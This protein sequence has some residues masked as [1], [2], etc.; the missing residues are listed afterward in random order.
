MSKVLILTRVFLRNGTD[1]MLKSKNKRG[2][3][4]NLTLLIIMAVLMISV[5]IPFGAF[6]AKGYDL[7]DPI[8]QTGILLGFG[9][10]LVSIAIFIFGIV[11]VLTTFYFSKDIENLLSLPVK[12]YQ[13]L[14]AKFITVLV[15]E[16]FTETIFL[17]PV[18]IA[19]GIKS[20]AGVVYYLYSAIV[21]LT[22][23]I[24]PLVIASA[25]NMFIM[26]FTNL[27]KHKDALKIAGGL[28]AMTFAIGINVVMQR[29]GSNI[30]ENPEHMLS[31]ITEGNNSL[32]RVSTRAFPSTRL[33]ALSLIESTTAKGLQNLILFLLVTAAFIGLFMVLAEM[34]Y[35]R[36]VVG[37]SESYSKRKVIV[38]EELDKRLTQKSSLKSYITKELRI[39]LRTPAYFINCV[40]MNFLLPAFLLLPVI[41][42]PK[43]LE[44]IRNASQLAD[45]PAILG[46]GVA[47]GFAL[48]VFL[49]AT[50]GITS[51]SISRE[52]QNLYV[53]KYLPLRYRDQ[54]MAK[55]LSG[56]I[57]NFI[58]VAIAVS[59][60]FAL[61]NPPVYALTLIAVAALQ[62]SLLMAFSG[63]FIDLHFPKLDWDNEQKAVKQN[64]N[65]MINMFLGVLVGAAVI[66]ITVRFALNLNHAFGL[67]MAAGTIFNIVLYRTLSTYGERLYMSIEP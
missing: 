29:A 61:I 22:L 6:I 15:Y 14:S 67:I 50:T 39:L 57:L 38:G 7:L 51:T 24:I 17:L 5:G 27:G 65:L 4:K 58:G 16:Y 34:L 66:F 52:G 23:P 8:G 36:G 32:I 56:V 1:T 53:S 18:L 62:G 54:I 3:S 2:I 55:V 42:Q 35:F 30:G 59:V 10:S 43:L 60:A 64:F 25:V 63:I 9:L 11:Y 21:F 20:G 44:D 48:G 28:L 12:P 37:V 26:R 49:A 19:Y 13:I 41:S 46:I 40:L 45:N 31:M 33:V 47:A